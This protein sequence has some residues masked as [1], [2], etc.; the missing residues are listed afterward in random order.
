M[1]METSCHRRVTTRAEIIRGERAG[2]IVERGGAALRS[3]ASA[4][5]QAKR[6]LVLTCRS[7]VREKKRGGRGFLE[8][9]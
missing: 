9:L 7:I 2:G 3:V 5:A 6:S 8:P 1:T 4:Q